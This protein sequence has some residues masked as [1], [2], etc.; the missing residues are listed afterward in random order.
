MTRSTNGRG[1]N[2]CAEND[3]A[4]AKTSLDQPVIR[5]A[6]DDGESRPDGYASVAKPRLAVPEESRVTIYGT[7]Q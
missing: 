1:Q 7:P 4:R 2:V 6:H 5:S 3:A